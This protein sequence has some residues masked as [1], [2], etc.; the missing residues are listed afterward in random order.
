MGIGCSFSQRS[1]W[2]NDQNNESSSEED[3]ELIGEDS[4][5]KLHSI[6]Q[7][8]NPV[9][10][11]SVSCLLLD[12]KAKNKHIPNR[13]ESNLLKPQVSHHTGSIKRIVM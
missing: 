8:D 4:H 6:M 11:R 3:Q 12:V 13:Q 2:L 5:I 9:T 7:P 10:N 1:D